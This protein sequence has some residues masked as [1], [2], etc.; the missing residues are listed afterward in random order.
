MQQKR[1]AVFIQDIYGKNRISF[2]T[3]EVFR[4]GDITE[5]LAKE[6]SKYKHGDME[7]VES[8]DKAKKV[9]KRCL[10]DTSRKETHMAAIA[11]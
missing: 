6:A 3:E 5:D 4:R 9:A 11:G 7:Y 8:W 10:G 1:E 2:K